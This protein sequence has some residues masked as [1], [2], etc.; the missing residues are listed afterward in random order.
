MAGKRKVEGGAAA[1][2]S[3]L[4]PVQKRSR[5]RY[6]HILATAAE[7]LAEKGSEAFRMSE[8]VER[9]GVAF[10]SLYQYFPDK[11][12]IIGTLAERY[13]QVGRDCVVRDLSAV[14][15]ISDLHPALCRIVDS[16]YR[17]FI[18]EPVMR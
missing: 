15:T 7:L 5:E 14:R 17:M 12:A 3:R 2:I 11:T 10:G 16:Y 18:D 13:N 6:E 9:A 1:G 4:V 8:L